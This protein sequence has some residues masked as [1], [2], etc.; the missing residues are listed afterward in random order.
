[1]P[2]WNPGAQT[3]EQGRSAG[4]GPQAGRSS[5]AGRRMHASDVAQTQVQAFADAHCPRH[6]SAPCLTGPKKLGYGASCLHQALQQQFGIART[7]LIV[8]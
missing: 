3:F 6:A 2:S 4:Q 1:M 8:K 5:P 7:R